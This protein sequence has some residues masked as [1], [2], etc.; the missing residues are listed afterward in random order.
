[1]TLDVLTLYIGGFWSLFTSRSGKKTKRLFVSQT[2]RFLNRTRRFKP[3][4]LLKEVVLLSH[5][6]QQLQIVL[7]LVKA[8]KLGINPG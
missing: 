3:L 6:L 8:P 2:K 1:M 4:V 7:C 5:H